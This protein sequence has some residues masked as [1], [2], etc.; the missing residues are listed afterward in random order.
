[1][2]LF[3]ESFKFFYQFK[4][5]L[6]MLQTSEFAYEDEN[7]FEISNYYETSKVSLWFE[8]GKILTLVLNM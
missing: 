2:K 3:F 8:H 6:V 5:T 7:C 1:M 4:A